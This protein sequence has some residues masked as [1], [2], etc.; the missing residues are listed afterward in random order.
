MQYSNRRFC[1][2]FLQRTN[3][4][5][6]GTIV[7]RCEAYITGFDLFKQEFYQKVI[8]AGRSE[9]TFKS[10]LRAI[11]Q[12][13]L[14]Y[15]CLPLKL[16]DKQINDYLTL[17]KTGQLD[18]LQPSEGYFKHTVFG[19]RYMFKMYGIEGRKVGMPVMK[20]K[21]P[22]R[23]IM[24]RYEVMTLLRSA[25]L[26][27]HTIA[28]ALAYGSGLR[29]NELVNV[30]RQD[31]DIIRK[32]V[33][34]RNG[35]GGYDRYV[36]ISDDFIRG[37]RKYVHTHGIDKYLFPGQV[38]GSALS[39]SAMQ[40]A[41][42]GARK[43]AG[44]L[45]KISMHNMRHS[46]AVHYLEDTGDLLRLKQNLGHRDIKNTMAYLK[47]AQAL[48]QSESYSPLTKVFDLV[49]STKPS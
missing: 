4:E 46:Y 24:N 48:P 33:H 6:K 1:Q 13:S 43:R 12:V 19:L 44:I 14:H 8:L 2:Q 15:R 36:P 11:A 35:K 31:I 22:L 49:R 30:Q 45:K 18:R 25:T 21:K 39:I 9:Q 7:S 41:L 23:D 10:Y 42:Q 38:K 47:Y 17:H 27:K 34:I 16:T 20:R 29:V 37:Y 32:T 5:K 3:Y 26:E 40:H 28:F